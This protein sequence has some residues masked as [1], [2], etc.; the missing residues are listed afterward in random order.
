[1]LKFQEKTTYNELIRRYKSEKAR[2]YQELE[3]SFQN[4]LAIRKNL[5]EE[6]KGLIGIDQPISETYK[7]FKDL[8]VRDGENRGMFPEQKQTTFG[9]PT[10]I[11]S[12]Y[13]MT[14][15]I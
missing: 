7:Q 9:K 13:F 14:F 5:I 12:V 6:L 3:K 1:M 8:Q 10:T 15:S 4:N 2:Y 11:T